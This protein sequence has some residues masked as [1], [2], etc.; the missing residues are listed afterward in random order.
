M[1]FQEHIRR[2]DW[3]L[4]GASVLLVVF[5]LVAIYSASIRG[6]DF[7]NLWK[8]IGFFGFSFLLMIGISFVDTRT[9]R[10][11]STM[12]LSLYFICVMLLIGLFFFAPEIRGIK[13]W[14]KI[15]AFSFDP[16]EPMKIVLIL[17]L[18]KYFSKR[19]VELYRIRHIILSGIYVLI[20]TIL[21]FLQPEF[22]SVIIIG[23]IWVSMLLVS[24]IK[25]RHF[26]GLC[27]VFSILFLS[28]WTF[29]LKDYQ[30]NRILSF[31]APQADPLGEGWSQNQASISIGS[32][33][34]FGKGITNGSQTQ[35]G[36]LPEPQTDFIFSVIGEETGLVGTTAV[37]GLFGILLWRILQI[38]LNAQ[39]NFSRLFAAGL[40]VSIFIQMFINIGMN[41]GILPVIGIPLPLVS[42]GGSNLLFLFI[43]LG[44]LQNMKIQEF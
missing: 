15:G 30:K 11:N 3:V 37:L 18:A 17:M 7:S 21:I 41:L 20:P 27:L 33:G 40:A 39:S 4:M 35:Y 12:L 10:E 44:I 2:M 8:Q 31:V 29:I 1:S 38:A 26:I 16:I 14:Y 34:L 9:I 25:I 42:Y 43:A 13:S 24:G 5:G 22:G 6:D 23:T 36:F 32:G 19:H 28:S